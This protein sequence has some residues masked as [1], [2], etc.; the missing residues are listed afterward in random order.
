MKKTITLLGIIYYVLL[1]CPLTGQEIPFN[2][3]PDWESNANGQVSTGL[4][5]AD[6]NNDGWKDIIVADGND[7]HRQHL[8]VYYNQGD[9]TFP[10]DPDWESSDID[11]HGHL[12][13]GDIDKDGWIDV[14]VSV[15]L[16]AAGFSSPG[17]VKVY[18]NN[19][20]TLE[21]TPSFQSEEFYTFSCALGD[22]DGDG[23][24]D[25]AT[26]AG[27]PY[28]SIFDYGKIFYNNNGVFSNS[29]LWNS[30]ITMGSLDVDFADMDA[31][32]FLDVIF[33]CE[34]TPNYI[35]LAD[36]EGNISEVPSWQSAESSNYINS[37]DIGFVNSPTYPSLTMTGNSQLGGDGKVRL[38]D[39]LSGIPPTS[40]A[41]WLS[42]S[43]G[44][45]SGILLADVTNN[46]ELDLIYGGWWLPMK[47]ALKDGN[48]FQMNPSY[49]S[50]TSSVVEAILMAD[51]DKEIIIQVQEVFQ[52][53]QENISVIY[54]EKQIIENIISIKKNGITLNYNEYTTVSNRNWIS[55]NEN[56]TANDEIIV[57][58]EY[59]NDGDIVITNWD[60]AKGNYIFYN[61]NEST[62]VTI[63]LETGFQF[64]SSNVIP[65]DP[66]M[67]VVM[68]DVLNDNLAF[69]RSSTGTM[70]RKIGPTW[71]NGI[72]DWII[73]EGYLVKMNADDSFAIEGPRI[74]PSTGIP[75][76]TGYQFVSYFPEASMDA[77]IAFGSIVGDNLDFIRNSEGGMVRKIG[78][79]WVNGIGDAAPG[80]G[81]LVKMFVDGE[82]IYPAAAK[83][84]GKTTIV[85]SHLIFEGGN[86]SEPV[87]TMYINGLEIGDEVAAYKGDV[88]LG[89]MTVSSGNVY[90]NDLPVFSQLT[91]GQGYVAG[92]P[93]SLKVW[94]N[95]NVV[96]AEFE[97]ESVYNSYVSTVYPNNDGE[98][99]V[100][101]MTKG[102]MLTGELVIY[103][104]PATN[105]IN[106]SSPNQIINVVI[107]NYVG[108]SVYEGN[109]TQ[110]NTSDFGAGVYIIRI[111][112]S[113]GIE[114]QKVTIK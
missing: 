89:S 74:N 35:Y 76:T 29:E 33:S 66:D 82:I 56:L 3:Y 9:G 85:P 71:V 17:Y 68:A 60:G 51:L 53:E 28:N 48:G 5:L 44:Y 23:D 58:Y 62:S 96:V 65:P 38:Y 11:Y 69:V 27:E 92:E 45:G 93:I 90:D 13:C 103:P 24:L 47:I 75:V 18:Y 87:Y 55:F 12:S 84:S 43:F 4:G 40:S 31:N 14:A 95:D 37:I 57:N 77:L 54:L 30:S 41:S 6:I 113:N 42:Q 10:L 105:M 2:T 78:P 64:I 107:F 22:A 25:L 50:S 88:I 114:T 34:E 104:N 21:A 101:N 99:S 46:G 36:D 109:S 63:N 20:G 72:G 67:M 26:T 81:Y 15:Y 91:N 16:G 111:E 79:N 59:S 86:A 110:I 61:T 73:D 108:Q 112:T 94:S 98:F 32:G 49:T 39:F 70:L 100:V 106:I 80:E 102:A 19:N 83:S 97:M 7:I 8:V 1:T 52:I